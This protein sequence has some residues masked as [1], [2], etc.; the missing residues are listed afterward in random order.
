M[1]QAKI[2]R[3][4]ASIRNEAELTQTALADIL[5]VSNR[6]ISKW[7]CGNGL[8]DVSLW[9]FLCETLHITADELLLGERIPTGSESHDKGTTEEAPANSELA[10]CEECERVFDRGMVRLAYNAKYHDGY[11]YETH[12]A[13]KYCYPCSCVITDRGLLDEDHKNNASTER[14]ICKVC[15]GRFIE[16]DARRVFNHNWKNR[17]NYDRDGVAGMCI[18]CATKYISN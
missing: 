9:R 4:I 10:I 6:T 15:G 5:G 11:D 3:F 16:D 8:P 18:G 13:G 12:I 7:E 1:D 17:Y 2:G 14:S